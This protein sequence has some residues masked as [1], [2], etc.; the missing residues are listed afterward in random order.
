MWRQPSKPLHPSPF[1]LLST[2]GSDSRDCVARP[3]SKLF[4]RS[5]PLCAQPLHLNS[6][7]ISSL[8]DSGSPS[9]TLAPPS[10]SSSHMSRAPFDSILVALFVSSPCTGQVPP[11][12]TLTPMSVFSPCMSRVPLNPV[13]APM[14]VSSLCMGWAP[15]DSILVH[16]SVLQV[17]E[18]EV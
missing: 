15:L 12:P 2:C 18:C 17:P 5:S 1:H 11:D 3:L 16:H 4:S 8:H 7:S 6:C 9:L 13:L 10:V 14:S